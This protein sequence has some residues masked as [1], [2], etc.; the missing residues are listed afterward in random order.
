MDETISHKEQQI[1]G[2]G[3]LLTSIRD[4]MVALKMG[5]T[6]ETEMISLLLILPLDVKNDLK[7][8]LD[9][10]NNGSEET[11][12]IELNKKYTFPLGHPSN[13]KYEIRK[14]QNYYNELAEIRKNA[15]R[16]TLASVV[17]T[18]FNKKYIYQEKTQNFETGSMSLYNEESED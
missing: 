11:A 15:V 13:N 6:G 4:I 8:I 18:L 2:P 9:K 16:T 12:I 10:F 5:M 1:N 14:N 3:L 17:D 7:E